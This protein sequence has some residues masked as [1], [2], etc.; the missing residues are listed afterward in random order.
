M[1]APIAWIAASAAGEPAAAVP[2]PHGAA[3]TASLPQGQWGD[4]GELALPLADRGLLLADG[5]FETVLLEEGRLQLLE[6]H[7]ERWRSSAEL[8]AMA[9][10]PDQT[11]ILPLVAEAIARSGIRTGA[12]RLNWSR[13]CG[14]RGLDLPAPAQAAPAHRFWLQLTATAPQFEAV[15]TWISREERRNA[16]SRLSRCKS[17]AYTAQ[18][19]ARREAHAAG[20]HDAL[21]LSSH[22][23]LCC[24]SAANL[25]VRHQGRWTTPP[26]ASGCLPG[27]MRGRALHLGRAC[28]GPLEPSDLKTCEGALLINSLGCRPIH[29]CDGTALAQVPSGQAEQL[30]RELLKEARP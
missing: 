6:E 12:L 19:Q 27:V 28:E 18:V 14:G 17:F 24:G 9:P 3:A 13:G 15:T 23:Q 22:G 25:L 26:L 4:P 16:A 8:L 10:P 20:A 2:H 1:T 21:L 5:L 29:R 11:L 7:L 30:W